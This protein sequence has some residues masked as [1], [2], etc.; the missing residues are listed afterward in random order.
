[1]FTGENREKKAE[2]KILRNPQKN[3]IRTMP[4]SI[5]F[6]RE[7]NSNKMELHIN[8]LFNKRFSFTSIQKPY[9]N[10]TF[11]NPNFHSYDW[12]LLFFKTCALKNNKTTITKAVSI[13]HKTIWCEIYRISRECVKTWQRY[14]IFNTICPGLRGT[15]KT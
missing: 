14:N 9:R 10:K 6:T 13:Y 2:V 8:E 11:K 4:F 5:V 3:G 7:W 12:L 1:M 15:W